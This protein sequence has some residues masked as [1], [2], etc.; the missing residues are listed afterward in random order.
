VDANGIVNIGDVRQLNDYVNPP[1]S[2]ESLWASDVDC[3][4]LV[5]IGDVRQ[6]NDYVSPP[7]SLNCCYGCKCWC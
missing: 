5:N 6:L 1:G 3:G 4:C 7:G 2:V